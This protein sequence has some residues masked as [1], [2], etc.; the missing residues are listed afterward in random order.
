[1]TV[2]VATPSREQPETDQITGFLEGVGRLL[3]RQALELNLSHAENLALR[4][5]LDKHGIDV[6]T[7]SGVISLKRIRALENV[8]DLAR[9]HLRDPT[10]E[11]EAALREATVLAGRAP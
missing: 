8:L 5:A 11:S 4:E 9:L 10:R 3:Y 1:M 6:P 7:P 2:T